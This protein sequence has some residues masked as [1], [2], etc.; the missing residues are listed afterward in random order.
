M[1]EGSLFVW[2]GSPS[3]GIN[4]LQVATPTR[5]DPLP[6]VATL[7][8]DTDGPGAGIAQKLSRRFGIL[9]FLS[10]NLDGSQPELVF[11]TQK[12]LGAAL[13]ELLAGREP[14]EASRTG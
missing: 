3:L 10:F 6:S 8:G 1:L 9:I 4:D 12:E 11:F 13:A 5:Y 14:T 7:R 2:V